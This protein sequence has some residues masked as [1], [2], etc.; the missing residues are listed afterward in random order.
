M[1][2]KKEKNR[3]NELGLKLEMFIK[4]EN[5]LKGVEVEDFNMSYS[6]LDGDYV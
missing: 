1:K 2:K 5:Y 4:I 3:R 6:N